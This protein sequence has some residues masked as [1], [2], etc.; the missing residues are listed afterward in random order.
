MLTEW[1]IIY[2]QN[3]ENLENLTWI[4]NYWKLNV[5]ERVLT[6]WLKSLF[7]VYPTLGLW[8]MCAR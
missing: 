5:G 4:Y 6:F 3:M 7:H 8:K 1:V 2:W